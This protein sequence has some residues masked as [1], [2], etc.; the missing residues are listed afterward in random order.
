MPAL[1]A[2]SARL[3]PERALAIANSRRA[4]RPFLSSLAS[5]RSTVAVRSLRIFNVAIA[6]L[7]QPNRYG[8]GVTFPS[9][10]KSRNR[11][12]TTRVKHY[13]QRY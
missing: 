4:T 13:A 5:L 9:S 8:Y 10:G 2:A 7:H 6:R 12:T 1:R 11:W 3:I